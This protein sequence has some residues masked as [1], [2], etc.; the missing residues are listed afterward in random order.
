VLADGVVA[1]VSASSHVEGW[2]IATV[3][4]DGRAPQVPVRSIADGLMAVEDQPPSL[5]E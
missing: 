5:A 2:A 4:Q 3:W 1:E